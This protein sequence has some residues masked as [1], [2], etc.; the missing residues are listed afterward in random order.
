MHKLD[1]S[2][3]A[4]PECLAEHDYKTQQWSDL[5][6]SCRKQVRKALARLQGQPGLAEQTEYG[7]RCAYCEGNIYHDGHIEHFRR[8]NPKHYPELTFEWSNLFMACGSSEH[9][10]HYKD[11]RQADAYDPDQL[12]KPD[13][14]DPEHYLYFHSSGQVRAREGLSAKDKKIATETIR[15]FGLNNG[16][17]TGARR[18]ALAGY[19]QSLLEDLE[20]LA[21]WSEMERVSYLQGEVEATRWDPYAT[22]VKHFLQ[23]TN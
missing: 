1:R 17:L 8:K 10:G 2:A 12:I 4:A 5:R 11:R 20:E 21:S 15:I 19:R 13:E 22:T 14:H 18:K 16:S 6:G 3:V 7:V 9:C 23:S